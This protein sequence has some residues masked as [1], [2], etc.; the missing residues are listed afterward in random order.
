MVTL[1]SGVHEREV[2]KELA[3]WLTTTLV[4]RERIL[5]AR[6]AFG[7]GATYFVRAPNN[8][9][10]NELPSALQ[11]QID[12]PTIPKDCDHVPKF[13]CF[14]IDGP[15]FALWEGFSKYDLAG[16]YNDLEEHLK[17]GNG[18]RNVEVSLYLPI[19]FELHDIQP[20]L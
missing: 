2:G 19:A 10:W 16:Q 4:T 17:A 5:E 8:W 15:W 12:S 1:L 14:G 20:R 6:I 3:E 9:K 7:P 13:V 18:T 11:S